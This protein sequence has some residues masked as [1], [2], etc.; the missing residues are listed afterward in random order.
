MKKKI[1]F[2]VLAILITGGIV[3]YLSTYLSVTTSRPVIERDISE[4]SLTFSQI[5]ENISPSVVS[6]SVSR[7]REE[8]NNLFDF[9]LPPDTERWAEQTLGSGVIISEDGYIITNNH[10]IEDAEEIKVTLVDKR[11]FIARIIGVDPKTD[12]AVIKID[13]SGLPVTKWANS[14]ELKPG[15]IVLAIGN[16]YGLSHSVT[17]GIVSATG[18]ANV[19]IADYEDF[20]QTDAA[21]NPGNSGGPLVNINGEIVGINTAIFSRSGGYQGIGF[22]VPSNMARTVFEQLIREGRIKRGWIGINIQELT[23][24]LAVKFSYKDQDGVLV[25]GVYPQSPAERAGI[26]RG[27]IIVHYNGR[28]VKDA[29]SFRNQVAST[30]PGKKVKI[31]IFR[32]GRLNDIELIIA[33]QS[34]QGYE[35]PAYLGRLHQRK[36]ALSGIDVIELTRDIARQMGFGQD[37]RGVIVLKIEPGSPADLAGL[38]R[39][40]LIKEIDRVS[41]KRIEDFQRITSRIQ[42]GDSVLLFINRS[43]REFY[44]VLKPF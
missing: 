8:E 39:G 22:A 28:P 17:M 15:D 26:K 14:D 44:T 31:K 10:V 23:P 43:G 20:I 6:I 13:V 11:S 7:T 27:D 2:I 9:I 40:D 30:F 18:R 32:D 4:T 1:A 38:K 41:I 29:G 33:E 34:H 42:P 19:G 5:V 3:Y 12:L 37:D 25:N 36:H 21:I 24:E 35:V 16:A